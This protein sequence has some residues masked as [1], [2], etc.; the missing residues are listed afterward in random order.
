MSRATP[1]IYMVLIA[2]AVAG[3]L[4]L[5]WQAMETRTT[6]RFCVAQRK[7]LY[8]RLREM[9]HSYEEIGLVFGYDHT[10]VMY[11]IHGG[12]RTGRVKAMST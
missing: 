9:R 4:G 8:V 11:A 5:D 1:P 7:A 10:T 3:E 6:R 2:R 12:A